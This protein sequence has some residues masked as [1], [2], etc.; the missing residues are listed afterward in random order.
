MIK[1][2]ARESLVDVHLAR[3]RLAD[4][5][6]RPSRRFIVFGAAYQC[7]RRDL[8]VGKEWHNFERL[9]GCMYTHAVRHTLK[10]RSIFGMLIR[11][12]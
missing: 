9:R 7:E 5:R 11:F 3:V 8:H 6:E 2:C 10:I 1:S 12:F 4:V